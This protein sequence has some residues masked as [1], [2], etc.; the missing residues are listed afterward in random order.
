MSDDEK[1]P[2]QLKTERTM[3]ARLEALE[4]GR[5]TKAENEAK[6]KEELKT[7]D[8]KEYSREQ[9]LW[10]EIFIAFMHTCEVKGTRDIN[11]IIERADEAIAVLHEKGKI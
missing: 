10:Q 6:R 7:S 4:R 3:K 5:K 9:K 8:K 2:E 1:S 11:T